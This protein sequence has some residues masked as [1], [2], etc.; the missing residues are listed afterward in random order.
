M[1][2][3]FIENINLLASKLPIIEESNEIFDEDVVPILREISELDLGAAI[4]DLKKGNYLGNRKLDI[5]LIL[6]MLDVDEEL[7]V[8]NPELAEAI[9][10]DVN[11]A[12]H[13]DKALITFVDGEDIELPFM[14]DGSPITVT[15]HGDLLAQFARLDYVYAKAQIDSIYQVTVGNSTDYTVT[16]DATPYTFT[17][18]I[19]ATREN[20]IAGIANMLNSAAVPVTAL[21]TDNGTK[22]NLTAKVPGN[23]FFASVSNNMA[24]NT[25]QANVIEGPVET[26]F[27]AK[28]EN[29][30]AANFAEPVVGEIV[31]LYDVIGLNSNVERI[32]LNAVSGSYKTQAPIYYWAN[33]TS[34]FQT[35][36]MR[37][38]DIIKLGTE[39]DNIILLAKRI[40]EVTEVQKRIPQLVDTFDVNNN[41]NGDETIYN[42]LSELIDVH[43]KLIE[44]VTLYNDLKVG[45][46]NY[47]Q[48][49]VQNLQGNN[50]IGVVASDLQLGVDS[51][52]NNI[53]SN[54]DK[55]ITVSDNIANVNAIVEVNSKIDLIVDTVIPN[56]PEILLANDSALIAS[57][58]ALEATNAAAIATAKNNEMKNVSVGT[59]ITGVP[60]TAAN[61]T[62]NP[63][64]SKFT[65]VIPKGDKGEKGEAFQV[66]ATGLIANR[67]LYDSR[68]VGFSFNAI[69]EGQIYFK[70]STTLGDWSIGSPFGK[71]DQGD[72]GD[73]GN[74]IVS[75]VFTSTTDPSGLAGQ[76]GATDTYTIN[77]DNLETDTFTVKNGVNGLSTVI[78]TLEFEVLADDIN[79]TVSI[80]TSG[81]IFEVYFNGMLLPTSDYSL[82]G[83]TVIV[84]KPVVIGDEI[85]VKKIVSVD[86]LNTYTQ[87][88]INTKIIEAVL[89]SKN[90]TETYAVSGVELENRLAAYSIINKPVI[91]SPVNLTVDYIG[92]V[93]STYITNSSYEG[94]QTKVIWECA[95]DTNFNNIIDSY[96]GSDNL[97]SW[98]PTIGLALTQVFIRTKQISDGHRSD[99][100]DVISFTT[101]DIYVQAPT[102]SISGKLSELVLTPTISL[103]AFS[104]YNG[105]D[106]H[107][108]TDYQVVNKAT[109]IVKWESL[110]NTVDKFEITTEQLDIQT[111]Y[112][113]RA[114]FNGQTYGSS[115][116]SEI[117]G[118]TINIYVEDPVLTVQGTPNSITLT[119]TISGTPFS[120]FNSTD[121]HVST[122]YR[123]IKVSD[124]TVAFESL[125]NTIDLTSI[126]VTGLSKITEYKFMIKY[127]SS[128]YGSSN[129]VEVTGTTLDIYVENPTLIV[130]GAPNNITLTPTLTG[131]AFSVYN[132]TAT[133]VSTDYRVVKVSD[134]SVAFES[135]GNTT[136][137]TSIQVIGLEKTTEYKFM[138]RYNSDSYGSSSWVE[139][140]GTTLDIYVVTPTLTVQGHPSDIG[141]NPTL[142]TSAFTIYNGSD[143]QLSTDYQ[144][145]KNSDGS[146][147]WES[148]GNTVDK[149][150]INSG[151]LVESTEYRF[152]ARHNSTNYGSSAW[153]EVIGTTKDVFS[154]TYGVNWNPTTDTYERTG[155]ASSAPLST[156]YPGL[157]QTQMKRCV[158]NANGT[159]KYFLDPTNST[160]K[161]DGT[162]AI[163][164]GTDGNV[165]VQ[166]PKFW[167]KY[168]FVDGKHKWLISDG[169][170][171]GFEL[172]PAFDREGTIRDFR[173]YPAYQG[174]TL[175]GKL[176]SGSGRVPTA[177]KTRATFRTE[178]A[179]NGTGW[180]QIDWNLLIAVELLYLTEYADF[181]TQAMLGQGITSGSTYTAVTGSSNS[182]GN[183]SSPST[184]TN[185]Q[186]MSYRGIEN[187]YGQIFKFIDGVNIKDRE[188]FVNKKPS[189]Y[190]DDVFTGDYVTTGMTMVA[191]TGYVKN[192]A[193]NKNGFISSDATGTDSTYIPDRQYQ[194][195]GNRIVSF[196]GAASDGLA[197]GGFSVLGNYAASFAS[198]SLGSAVSF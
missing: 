82:T 138:I 107:T 17:S 16:I 2:G 145:L 70:L 153:V 175:S 33:T 27:L 30:L 101:P 149:L 98:T 69:D 189:T 81:G 155:V 40:E 183:A 100:S 118:T 32:R 185:T 151:A 142:T 112:T 187:W 184:N 4:A 128:I 39:I 186:F 5:N 193:Q 192:I 11:K 173:Y 137:L 56:I 120:I 170:Q 48:A 47:V 91:T 117:D 22:L 154:V 13:Y 84:N 90:Y 59:T 78:D 97:T 71:G 113:F 83:S 150:T 25:I 177:N 92:A 38:N 159:V 132:S 93:T 139:V 169:E 52:I 76:S 110:G 196:G 141:K 123:V 195:T 42:N 140:N 95:L 85:I 75:T 146:L 64:T 174:F 160:K 176:I 35:L 43:S 20:I 46:T 73:S 19:E 31:R 157:I 104:V 158:L 86:V 10:I 198:T 194:G 8:R 130:S 165:M 127:N 197:A 55:V 166:I 36:S 15:T 111:E 133:H 143:V 152:R 121:N 181:D 26:A 182:L 114:R 122:D 1:A 164:D 58:K 3:S 126:Q 147:V 44:I 94:L 49:V 116:W 34:A 188:Y 191:T 60:G 163:I 172:H 124:G 67:S 50:T 134:N 72:K 103:S 65:F 12:V 14:F 29:T 51:K 45:G 88:A 57:N 21:V 61:V 161:A 168:E 62:Y 74:S 7:L 148:L 54:I 9:W 80:D 89:Q 179:A 167:Y 87:A 23:P 162:T 68:P 79:Y 108:S 125:N 156:S 135:L 190:A 24:I 115:D 180:S 105:S 136:N 131:S 37:A 63:L 18:D 106:T 144:I 129:W 6:N 28:L 102:I 109:G 66:N 77:Y 96:E 41:P 119:P 171:P 99:F 53:G 178:A